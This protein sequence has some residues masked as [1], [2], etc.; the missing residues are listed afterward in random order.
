MASTAATR[1]A[2]VEGTLSPTQLV[3]RWLEAAHAF[4]SLDAYVRALL[5]EPPERYP[6]NRLLR[7]V[8]AGVRSTAGRSRGPELDGVIRKALRETAFRFELV[9]RINTTT[10]DLVER[11]QLMH[12]ALAGYGALLASREHDTNNPS[13]E[14]Q[15][16]LGTCLT[17]ADRQVTELLAA[18]EAR[19]IVEVRYLAGHPALFPAEVVRFAEVLELTKV[20][21]VLAMRLA[22]LDGVPPGEPGQ[23]EAVTRRAAELVEDLVEPARSSALEKLDEGRRAITIATDWLRRMN[24][25][26]TMAAGETATLWVDRGEAPSA[27]DPLPSQGTTA[28]T[29]QLSD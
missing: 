23:P 17:I 18:Q 2:N 26:G 22:E 10:H 27:P 9:F 25:R 13:V 20:Q 28:L 6:L 12:L 21:T 14:Y 4:G 3:V 16:Q 19:A 29:S 7:E 5:D 8:V 1:L 11:G 24:A 15:Q